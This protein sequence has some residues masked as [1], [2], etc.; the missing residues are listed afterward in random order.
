[1]PVPDLSGLMQDRTATD[2]GFRLRSRLHSDFVLQHHANAW[3]VVSEGLG[4]P[5]WVPVLSPRLMQVGANGIRTISDSEAASAA[6]EDALEKDRKHGIKTIPKGMVIASEFLPEG[7]PEGRYVRSL[8]AIDP[9][10]ATKGKCHVEAWNV[11]QD[12]PPGQNH[13][14]KFHRGL[15]NK[16]RAH[17]VESGVIEP[18]TEA[19]RSKLL[20]KHDARVL[21]AEVDP[22]PDEVRKRRVKE[23]EAVRDTVKKAKVPKAKSPRA[24][25]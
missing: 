21:S 20:R 8:D 14:F 3:E 6:Y 4:A 9:R 19:V 5:T 11:P 12:V 25:K 23:K 16:W 24:V 1:M 13:T 18:P 15:W 7:V 22:L 10:T 17:L 2:E